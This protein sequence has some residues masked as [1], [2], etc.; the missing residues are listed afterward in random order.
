MGPPLAGG[1]WFG[2]RSGVASNRA[3]VLL[4]PGHTPG[5]YRI[6]SSKALTSSMATR[7]CLHTPAS[8]SITAVALAATSTY[9]AYER[10]LVSSQPSV[11]QLGAGEPAR[12]RSNN[13]CTLFDDP[14]SVRQHPAHLDGEARVVGQFRPVCRNVAQPLNLTTAVRGL[15]PLC[16]VDGLTRMR[17]KSLSRSADKGDRVRSMS[18]AGRRPCSCHASG[19]ASSFRYALA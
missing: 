2:F 14:K 10:M 12:S 5:C 9:L 18:T 11:A 19:R 15:C 7:S 1:V 13:G 6:S 17:T 16:R 8:P 3:I 4:R